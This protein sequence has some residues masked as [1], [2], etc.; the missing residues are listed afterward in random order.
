MPRGHFSRELTGLFSRVSFR[1]RGRAR[2]VAA[3]L[4]ASA[5][6]ASALAYPASAFLGCGSSTPSNPGGDSGT[7]ALDGAADVLPTGDSGAPGDGASGGDSAGDAG[8]A[9]TG[10]CPGC[11][12]VTPEAG[13]PFG[14]EATEV[15][16]KAYA[17]WLATNPDAT[18]QPP[19]CTWNTSFTPAKDWPAPD[20]LPVANVD[21]CDA[22]AYCAAA[23]KTLCGAIGGQAAPYDGYK[24]PAVDQ[25][26]VACSAS[27]TLTYPYG[28]TY[29]P[30]K[31]NGVDYDAG[32]LVDAGSLP[33]CVG[34]VPGLFDMSGNVWEWENACMGDAGSPDLCRRRGGSYFSDGGLLTCGTG[35]FDARNFTAGY[36]GFRCCKN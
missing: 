10:T 26:F 12:V 23:N 11:V 15:T 1:T 24:D 32:A 16:N 30:Q 18:K 14:I 5:L 17:T 4:V 22:Y 27:G 34:S 33:G 2:G 36:I 9:S 3:T 13:A 8:D 20:N 35:G 19:F 31:C 29:D 6:V 28:S 21:W 25:W 7:P